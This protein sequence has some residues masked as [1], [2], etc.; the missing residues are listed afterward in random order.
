MILS[1]SKTDFSVDLKSSVFIHEDNIRRFER[2]LVG[3]QDL[4]VVQSLMKLCILRSLEGE[5]PSVKI[6]RQGSSLKIL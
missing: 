1:N 3:K 4:T 5:M 6:I 2:I